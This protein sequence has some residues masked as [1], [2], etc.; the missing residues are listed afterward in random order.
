M[1]VQL[2]RD[3]A[4]EN[5]CAGI[6]ISRDIEMLLSATKV[7]SCWLVSRSTARG[8][9]FGR[10]RG[11]RRFVLGVAESVVL[12]RVVV[13]QP[14]ECAFPDYIAGC[15]SDIPNGSFG[16]LHGSLYQSSPTC[17]ERRTNSVPHLLHLLVKTYS[18]PGS[19]G[20]G[21]P[22]LA[23]FTHELSGH[24]HQRCAARR[25]RC[26]RMRGQVIRVS[27]SCA[28]DARSRMLNAIIVIS[29][30]DFEIR[31]RCTCESRQAVRRSRSDGVSGGLWGRRQPT[32]TPGLRPTHDYPQSGGG[33]GNLGSSSAAIR[34]D[35]CGASRHRY[36]RHV[37]CPR[38]TCVGF[39]SV[40]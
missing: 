7:D 39:G 31:W 25:R 34:G 6:A 15:R 29:W 16:C 23:R 17:M 37:R 38:V 21:G 19:L 8:C 1:L 2:C 35:C 10:C 11:T 3:E 27:H 24:F 26:C 5:E 9:R 18:D 36:L 20:D 14:L 40:V 22:L 28:R 4:R 30:Q 12:R 13:S 32:P 33:A